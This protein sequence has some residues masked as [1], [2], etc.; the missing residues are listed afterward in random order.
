[1]IKSSGFIRDVIAKHFH[2]ILTFI[3]LYWIFTFPISKL[4]INAKAKGNVVID[5]FSV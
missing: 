3:E 4:T 1:M 5:L 2:T